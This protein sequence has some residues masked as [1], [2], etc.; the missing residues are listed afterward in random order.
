[1]VKIFNT[2]RGPD[3]LGAAFAN[4][5]KSLFGDT[6]ANAINSEKLYAAQRENT[7][8]DNLMARAAKS[9]VQNLGADPITQAIL[10]GS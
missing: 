8:M 7:E 2:L 6:T 1:M 10:L 3:P 4:L 5:G 9:G